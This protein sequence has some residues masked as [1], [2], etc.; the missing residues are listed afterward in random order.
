MPPLKVCITRLDKHLL[1]TTDTNDPALREGQTLM[2]PGASFHLHFFAHFYVLL[3]QHQ[4][5]GCGSGCN[6]PQRARSEPHH[7][8]SCYHQG[9]FLSLSHSQ[10]LLLHSVAKYAPWHLQQ[11][12]GAGSKP[13]PSEAGAR[14]SKPCQ[15]SP[16]QLCLPSTGVQVKQ[17]WHWKRTKKQQQHG[18]GLL[19]T[20]TGRGGGGSRLVST[21]FS[22]SQGYRC[23]LH[24]CF[25]SRLLA[26]PS[27][28]PLHHALTISWTTTHPLHHI[29]PKAAPGL[30]KSN[31]AIL[32]LFFLFA[33]GFGCLSGVFL[34]SYLISCWKLERNK[35]TPDNYRGSGWLEVTGGAGDLR[36][37][38]HYF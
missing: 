31:R 15:P 29:Y 25:F 24:L 11:K 1:E 30:S 13:T 27:E 16:A 28:L 36:A 23:A 33:L 18:H 17:S 35:C 4:P 10:E 5:G 37:G 38:R 20:W 12:G 7:L 3:W 34:T 14:R 19:S 6:L 9:W 26:P 22:R 2:F 8:S 32:G 21:T